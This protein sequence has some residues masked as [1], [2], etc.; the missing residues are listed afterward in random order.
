M[1]RKQNLCPR[2]KKNILEVS[3]EQKC[4]LAEAEPQ[5]VPAVVKLT[6]ILSISTQPPASNL[7]LVSCVYV[8]SLGAFND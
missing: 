5:N 8:G 4:F 7:S 1:F 2:R 3:E 6:A